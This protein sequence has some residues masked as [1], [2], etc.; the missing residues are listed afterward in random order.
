[1]VCFKA[2]LCEFIGFKDFLIAAAAMTLAVAFFRS[3]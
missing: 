1:M 3:N 2:F